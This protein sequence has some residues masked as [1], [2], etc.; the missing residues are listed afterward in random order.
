[1]SRTT[2]RRRSALR[3]LGDLL[4]PDGRPEGV[5][6]GAPADDVLALAE[7]TLL[8]PAL[9]SALPAGSAASRSERLRSAHLHNLARNLALV[10][11]VST[12]LGALDREGIPAAPLKGIDAVLEEVYGDWGARTMADLD[13]LVDPDAATAARTVLAGLGYEPTG[14]EMVGHHHLTP[15]AAPG[16]VGPVEVHVGLLDRP[17]PGFLDPR[18]LLARATPRG[19]RPGLRLDRTDAATHQIDH[20]QHATS[21]H[22]VELDL[23]ALHETALLIRRVPAVDWDRVQDRFARAGIRGRFDGHVALAAELFAID[24]PVPLGRAGCWAAGLELFVD[25]HPGLGVVDRPGRRFPK[26]RRAR[27]ERYY[28]TPLPGVAVWRARTRYLGEVARH[29]RAVRQEARR[30]AVPPPP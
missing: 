4:A 14:E 21:R 6:D 2:P 29:R 23:R 27:L 18:D 8:L 15:M 20:A 5:A 30:G 1:M 12:I 16:R 11:E 17:V 13:V 9:R 22:R 3:R 26:L 7:R 19:D 25:D 24:A 10:E 28:G